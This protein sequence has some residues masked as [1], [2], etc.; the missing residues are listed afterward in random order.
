[1]LLTLLLPI[2]HCTRRLMTHGHYSQHTHEALT[3]KKQRPPHSTAPQQIKPDPTMSKRDMKDLGV[4]ALTASMARKTAKPTR[5]TKTPKEAQASRDLITSNIAMSGALIN[6]LIK[7]TKLKRWGTISYP[8]KIEKTGYDHIR[9][10]YATILVKEKARWWNYLYTD[11]DEI[12]KNLEEVGL[13]YWEAQSDPRS[14]IVLAGDCWLA[15]RGQYL[16]HEGAVYQF[17]GEKDPK[18][19][20]IGKLQTLP[21]T[22]EVLDHDPDEIEMYYK[23]RKRDLVWDESFFLPFP[24]EDEASP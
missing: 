21:G 19:T 13:L 10:V 3:T 4:D 14:C 8:P 24:P 12:E 20:V 18:E 17:I 15:I 9:S 5:K 16:I 7:E 23:H 22:F 1:M 11:I 2:T 6:A